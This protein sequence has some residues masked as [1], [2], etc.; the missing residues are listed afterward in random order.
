MAME[1]QM[2]L[3]AVGGL[4][5]D[6][7][8]RDP[9]SGNEIPPG[10]M[11]N[12]VRD[13][14]DAKLSDGEYVV[15][16][17][18]VRFFGVK[19][20]ED[21]RTKAMKGLADMEANGRIGGEPVPADMPMQDQLAQGQPPISNDEMQMLQGMMNKGGVIRGYQEGGLNDPV[22]G[23]PIPQS[24]PSGY[25]PLS[26]FITPGAST[27][28]S[29][30]NPYVAPATTEP[31]MTK[32]PIDSDSTV[33]YVTYEKPGT[34]EIRVIAFKGDTPVNPDEVTSAIEAGY[35]P[36]GSSELESAKQEFSRDPEQDQSVDDGTKPSNRQ[37][38]GEMLWSVSRGVYNEAFPDS[39]SAGLSN[40][41]ST[42]GTGK[43]LGGLLPEGPS[44]LEESIKE[45]KERLASGKDYQ[46][47][48]I[49]AAE[50]AALELI[51]GLDSTADAK[52][53]YDTIYDA[54]GIHLGG[55]VEGKYKR[56]IR[57]PD[58]KKATTTPKPK[59][60]PVAAVSTTPSYEGARS[61]PVRSTDYMKEMQK[62]QKPREKAEREARVD[63]YQ[64][65]DPTGRSLAERA[66]DYTP[67]PQ[68][69]EEEKSDKA[70]EA[71]GATRSRGGSR[72]FGMNKGGLIKKPTKKKKTKK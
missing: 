31:P 28:S 71:A 72:E 49:N 4:D 2:E 57:K 22:T 54:Y 70:A 17:N 23:K 25:Y 58:L 38:V 15:P 12:E 14:V 35:F 41:G 52:V 21:L 30:L 6:G 8:T 42:L 46:G 56:D 64:E 68:T 16:A 18:V 59:D 53:I 20:F 27:I 61:I 33:R 11:A 60:G 9:V 65:P 36:Q 47:V 24:I 55:S 32:M 26:Q 29:N 1:K 3:F 69:E 48:P 66:R 7:M 44:A 50:K 34:G 19:F 10:S 51:A 43:V 62:I 39:F 63:A 45:A 37:T 67:P 5:D 40:V 13:D